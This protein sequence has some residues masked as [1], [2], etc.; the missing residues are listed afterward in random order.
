MYF[1]CICWEEG[2]LH[3]LLLHHLE[4]PLCDEGVLLALVASLR[5]KTMLV[6][7]VEKTINWIQLAIAG[8]HSC[9]PGEEALLPF[10]FLFCLFVFSLF[11]S[12]W[13]WLKLYQ[14]CLSFQKK[15]LLVSLIFS[16]VFSIS[17]IYFLSD[18][19]FLPSADFG[20]CLFFF[21]LF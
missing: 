21:H 2:D 10:Y 17:F 4:G 13:A 19:Y 1:W 11:Y 5:C 16:I 15:Q 8:E 18:Y 7:W 6:L 14:F 3:V 20:L 9:C 12:W